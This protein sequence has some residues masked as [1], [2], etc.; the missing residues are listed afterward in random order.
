MEPRGELWA[1]PGKTQVLLVV[2]VVLPEWLVL[3]SAAHS[4]LTKVLRPHPKTTPE[5]QARPPT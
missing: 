1:E 2:L 3:R 5:K 4:L